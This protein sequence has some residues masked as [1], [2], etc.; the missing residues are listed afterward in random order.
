LR[1]I[2]SLKFTARDFGPLLTELNIFKNLYEIKGTEQTVHDVIEQILLRL[3]DEKELS[4]AGL[5]KSISRVDATQSNQL[6]SS[7]IA[8]FNDEMESFVQVWQ[9]IDQDGPLTENSY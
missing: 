4:Q 8:I 7:L 9:R 5:S 1:L 6:L 2:R 3:D